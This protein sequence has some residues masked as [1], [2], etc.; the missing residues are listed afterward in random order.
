MFNC[1]AADFNSK[2]LRE[3]AADKMG[4]QKL[5]VL[6]QPKKK[7]TVDGLW[8]HKFAWNIWLYVYVYIRIYIYIFI[9]LTTDVKANVFALKKHP[10]KVLYS[11]LLM[12]V[13]VVDPYSMSPSETGMPLVHCHFFSCQEL[14]VLLAHQP[15]RSSQCVMKDSFRK[16]SKTGWWVGTTDPCGGLDWMLIVT[17]KR[18][19]GYMFGLGC[20]PSWSVESEG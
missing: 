20:S 17:S 10:D 1:A 18:H 11:Q 4:I 6:S 7:L 13:I 14:T 2:G 12:I 9:L 19:G 15:L 8:A 16:A 3:F 5:Q